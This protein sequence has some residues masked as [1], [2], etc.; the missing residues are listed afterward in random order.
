PMID[1][2]LASMDRFDTA[3]VRTGIGLPGRY[4]IATLHR[5]AN[6]DDPAAAA[7]LVQ[8][9]HEVAD[10]L[11]VVIPVHPLGRAAL[12]AAGLGTHPRLHAAPPLG[13]LEFIALVRGARAV[14][15][16]S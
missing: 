13:Y 9:L 5:P 8:A 14:I 15:T 6:V 3:A 7:A 2:L 12:E 11:D 1:T 16:D 10:E 4:V